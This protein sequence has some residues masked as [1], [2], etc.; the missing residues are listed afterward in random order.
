MKE[1][2]KFK[3]NHNSGDQPGRESPIP[4]M[5]MSQRLWK[6]KSQQHMK[7]PHRRTNGL[8]QWKKKSQHLSKVCV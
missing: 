7:M 5:Q 4:T 8:R 6:K 2:K 1:K 3:R